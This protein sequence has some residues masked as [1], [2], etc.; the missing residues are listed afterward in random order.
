MNVFILWNGSFGHTISSLDAYA[1]LVYPEQSYVI[2]I[3]HKRSNEFLCDLYPHLKSL[4]IRPG[5]NLYFSYRSGRIIYNVVRLIA[6]LSA[7]WPKIRI[8]DRATLYSL[9]KSGP[10]H[11]I[12]GDDKDDALTNYNN[13]TGWG[14]L[15]KHRPIPLNL[16]P[17]VR[18]FDDY[19]VFHLRYKGVSLDKPGD[20]LRNPGEILNYVKLAHYILDNSYVK[21][22]V[23]I[24]DN[25]IWEEKFMGIKGVHV[26]KPQKAEGLSLIQNSQFYVC[27]HSGPVN[28]CNVCDVPVLVLDAL[29]WWQGTY[30]RR[31]LILYKIPMEKEKQLTLFDLTRYDLER[32]M[33]YTTKESLSAKDN[34]WEE[35]KLAF[36]EFIENRD[37]MRIQLLRSGLDE[38]ILLKYTFNRISAV[39]L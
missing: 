8:Y 26:L 1:R 15:V 19:C 16:L 34:S 32:W 12:S 27:Q 38:R 14:F 17:Q 11:F 36:I 23:V 5:K 6:K 22:V 3:S 7:V 24:S 20:Y 33:L 35:M 4:V 31:D 30:S 25:L 10:T 29:P 2:H 9:L 13:I 21:N 28:L 39:N 37:D 18:G